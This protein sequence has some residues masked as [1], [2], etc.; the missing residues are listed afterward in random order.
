MV[1]HPLITTGNRSPWAPGGKRVAWLSCALSGTLEL[2]ER[3]LATIE[4]RNRGSQDKKP[5]MKCKYA[6][7]RIYIYGS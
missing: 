6:K 2:E 5:Q 1:K 7:R 3:E 4:I